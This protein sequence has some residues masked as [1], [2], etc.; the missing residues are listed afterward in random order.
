MFRFRLEIAGEVQMD[1]GIA[2][3]ADGISDY[4]PVWSVI[5]YDFYAMAKRASS[6]RKARPAGKSGLLL[7]EKYA[8][9][10]EAHFP[11]KPI[12][13]RSGGFQSLTDS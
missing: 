5:E 11:G 2:R 13:E 10:K 4:R 6:R 7:S 1:R 8:G 3:F 12:L 9:W